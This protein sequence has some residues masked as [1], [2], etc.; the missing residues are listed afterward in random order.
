MTEQ[1]I[2]NSKARGDHHLVSPTAKLVAHLRAG[3]DIPYSADIDRICEAGKTTEELFGTRE[4]LIW[5]SALLELRY[6]SLSELLKREMSKRNIR[7]V[8]E[9]ACGIQPRGLIMSED[10]NIV[11]VETDLPDMAEEKRRLIPQ[12]SPD[13]LKRSNYHIEPLNVLNGQ[14]IDRVIPLLGNEA[15]AVINEGLL[16][17][18]SPEEKRIAA[19]NILAIIERNG[20]VWITPDISNSG[21]LR[22]MVNLFPGVAEVLSKISKATA[23]NLASHQVGVDKESAIQFYTELGFRVTEYKQKELVPEIH[24]LAEINDEDVRNKV[25]SILLNDSNIWVLEKA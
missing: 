19:Q 15:V 4:S 9:L 18:L 5:M 12:L 14:D 20:G 6:K 2:R 23:R 13:A 8:L 1:V 16:P 10:P 25:D 11:Y 3:T 24:S 7:Q 21:R 22:S 17:Y